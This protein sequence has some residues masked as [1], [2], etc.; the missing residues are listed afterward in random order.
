MKNVNVLPVT[1]EGEILAKL[2]HRFGAKAQ[3]Q[4]SDI[5]LETVLTSGNV[6]KR[7]NMNGDGVGTRP[8]EVF[9]GRN[10]LVVT[11]ALKVALNQVVTTSNGTNGNAVDYTYPDLTVFNGAGVFPA[12][13]ENECLEA[14][15]GGNITIKANT[16]EI[17]NQMQLRRFRIVPDTQFAATTQASMRDEGFVP[18]VQPYIFSGRDTNILEFEPAVGADTTNIGGQTGGEQPTQNILVFHFK[19]FVV[20]NGA[21]PLTVEEADRVAQVM[22]NY[23]SSGA[24]L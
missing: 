3:I 20:R 5:R 16:T 12:L 23:T 2:R 15:Y 8:L 14:V 11:Y 13:P 7:F 9:I 19:S 1:V 24:L 21:Q 6:K 18:F 10:D 17:L 4:E 22:K